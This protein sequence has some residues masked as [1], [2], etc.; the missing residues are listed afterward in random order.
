MARAGGVP[1]AQR[2]SLPP[3]HLKC[4]DA[5]TAYYVDKRQLPSI[6]RVRG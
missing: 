1:L 6:L 4:F 2:A 3:A 5:A